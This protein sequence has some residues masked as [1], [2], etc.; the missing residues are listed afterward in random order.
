M[1]QNKKIKILALTPIYYPHMGGAE[2]TVDELF[3]RLSK[4]DYIID[5]VTPNM[6]GEEVEKKGNFTTYRVGKEQKSKY[7]KFILY[8]WNQYFKAKELLKK[9]KYDFLH[10]DFAFPAAITT[11]LLIK[12]FKIPLV[13]T[14]FHLGTGMD[15]IHGDQNPF[16]VK[17]VINKIYKK[18]KLILVISNEQKEFVRKMSGRK[19]PIVIP[20]GTDH[21]KFTPK[22]YDKSLLEKFDCNGPVFI[23]VSRLS[24]R[25][26]IDEMI[27]AIEIVVKK[28]PKSKL[29]IVGKGEEKEKLEKL[30]KTLKLENN[31]V[32]T[33]FVSDEDLVNLYA[34]AD[35]FLLTSKYEGFGIANC[36]ALA[37]GTPVITYDTT[38]ASDYLK[39]GKTGFI[40]KHSIKEFASKVLYLLDNPKKLKEFSIN[41][42][43]LIEKDYT[44]EI[45]ANKHDEIFK[46]EFRN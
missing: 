22:N 32:F 8:Q 20:Q 12:K 28:Y 16:Y 44:W 46:K 21:I 19:D 42:R 39:D 2:R 25:K 24:K 45:Y 14:E 34:T 37:S 35:I 29:L 13:T 15:I 9:S 27:K 30:I 40:T 23:T 1:Q 10:I 41:S 4:K 3:T 33:G 31:V 5:L 17:P 43:E 38:A 7:L 18:S 26:C 6:G 11:L 36:E